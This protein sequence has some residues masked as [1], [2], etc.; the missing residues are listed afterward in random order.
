M[1]L[2]STLLSQNGYGWVYTLLIGGFIYTTPPHRPVAGSAPAESQGFDPLFCFWE[3]VGWLFCMLF[4]RLSNSR[5]L[6]LPVPAVLDARA[7]N[8]DGDGNIGDCCQLKA[9]HYGPFTRPR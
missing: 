9:I 5:I 7:Y 6:V 4:R 3:K 8:G 2:S 1:A